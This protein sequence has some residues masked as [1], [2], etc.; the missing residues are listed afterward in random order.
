MIL[1]TGVRLLDPASMTDMSA[2]VLVDDR[3][4]AHIGP[5]GSAPPAPDARRID[6]R[7]KCLAPGLVD[8]LAYRTDPA[9]CAAGG[10]T[11]LCL[12]PDQSPPLDDPA[13]VERAE[14]LGKPHVWVHPFAAATRGLGGEELAEIGLAKAAGAVA[15]ATGRRAV[16]SARVMHRLLAYAAGLDLPVVAHPE[17]PTLT[18]DTVATSGEI[19]TRAGLPAAPAFAEPLQIARDLAL[20]DATAAHL[21]IAP[22]TTAAGCELIRAAKARGVRVT[23]ATTPAHL[24]L[25]EV[26]IG[27]Y[28]SYARL[29]PP[30]RPETDRRAVVAA[31]LDGTI[32]LV[33]SGHDPRSQD[34]KRLPFADAAPGAAG[35]T[36]LL[37]LTLALAREGMPLL[38]VIAL[39]TS[40]PARLFNLPGGRV[41]PGEPAD[42]VLFDPEAAWRIDADTMPGLAGNTPFDGMPVQGRVLLTLKGGVVLH[43]AFVADGRA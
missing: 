19:A 28:R 17:E 43:N 7:G 25:T 9:A 5:P 12:M 40:T 20:A 10:I 42:L 31:V 2:D 14:R 23:A 4:I 11:R 30:L 3:R 27:D 39:I 8:A 22:V 1:F 15:A 34:Q 26:A 33:A 41:A 16:A 35:A 18:D 29:S 24:F 13:L 38:D 6:G 36:T 32:D 37:A 21:H